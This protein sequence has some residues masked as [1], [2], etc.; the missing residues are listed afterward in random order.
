MTAGVMNVAI[1]ALLDQAAQAHG[2]P[3]ALLRAV[4]WVESRGNPAAVSP[5]GAMGILQLMPRTARGLGVADPLDPAQNI[6][7]GARYLKQLINRFD[8][9]TGRALAGYNWGPARV[10][11][12]SAW[13]TS[14]QTYVKRVA[15]RVGIE[16][17]A[18]ASA[19]TQPRIVVTTEPEGDGTAAPPFDQAADDQAAEH[20]RDQVQDYMLAC[21]PP[22]HCLSCTCSP[23]RAE[24]GPNDA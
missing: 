23:L 13:P 5:A 3:P 20:S 17:R 21:Y 12:G 24:G 7:G 2:L 19:T 18:L 22:P 14:V 6:D 11:R 15:A 9:D 8:G 1:L 4:A 10:A 16:D